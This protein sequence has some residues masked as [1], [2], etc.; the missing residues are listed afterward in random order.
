MNA[1]VDPQWSLQHAAELYGIEGWANDFFTITADGDV[2]VHLPGREAHR[3]VS[4]MEIIDGIKARGMHM[5]VL[6]RFRDI[7]DS[8]IARINTGFRRAMDTYGYQGDYRGVYPIKVN[9]QH[10][11]IEEVVTSGRQ[12]HHGLEAGSKAELMIAMAYM[13]DPEAFIIC[14]GYKDEEFVDL[15]LY[16]QQL[17]LQVIQVIEMP[18]ELELIMQRSKVLGIRPR[19]GIRAK[20]ST[21]AEGKWNDS[22]GDRSVFGLTATEI[23]SV[24]DS[25]KAEGMLDCLQMLHFH[26]GSQIPSISSIRRA[27]SEG[28]RFYSDLKREGC[29]MGIIDIGGGLAIDYDGAHTTAVSS[30]NYGLDEYC[31]D[32]IEAIQGEMDKYELVHP[33]IISESGRALVAH[34]SVLVFNILDVGRFQVPDLPQELDEDVSEHLKNLW[35]VYETLREERLQ[36]AFHDAHFYRDALRGAFLHGQTSLRE[37]ALGD[38]IFWAIIT[39]IEQ[40]SRNI[41]HIP[42]ELESLRSEL[43]DIYYGNFSLFQS[44]PDSWAIDQLFPIMPLHRLQEQPQREATLSDITCDCDGKID[45]FVDGDGN[46]M[47]TSLPV[48]D[49][50]PGEDYLLGVFLVGAYQETLG[51]LHNLFGDTH[52]VAVRIDD[53]DEIDYTDEVQGD[54][55]E[56]VLSYVEY[57]PKDLLNQVRNLAEQAIRQKRI[58]TI[59]R[60]N[61]LDAYQNSMRGYTYYEPDSGSHIQR[62]VPV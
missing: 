45:S 49:I 21:K 13:H 48:H 6:L 40:I 9:Q 27:V 30:R 47:R 53:D 14:N 26:L 7:I 18:G 41:D 58:S 55:V 8:R 43:G 1:Q 28:A 57:D 54:T 60:R 44:L 62:D 22:G 24:V 52:V 32:V 56:D 5:P 36:E 16:A 3:T 50:R 15:A 12:F 46:H 37:R 11:V 34:S 51:D 42:T 20:L 25:L 35:D 31:T 17:G 10:Q 29:A 19:M 38:R 4:F 23:I 61:I 39:R 2:A 33:T 59:Q